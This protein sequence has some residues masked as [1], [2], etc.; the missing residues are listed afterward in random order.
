MLFHVAS[1]DYKP[2]A[3]HGLDGTEGDDMLWV[4]RYATTCSSSR[5]VHQQALILARDSLSRSVARVYRLP[6][7]TFHNVKARYSRGLGREEGIHFVFCTMSSTL[8]P[9]H[10]NDQCQ[11][12]FLRIV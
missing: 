8:M 11:F 10:G 9:P 1:D 2:T 5:H 12:G 7:S 4:P 3:V 6:W